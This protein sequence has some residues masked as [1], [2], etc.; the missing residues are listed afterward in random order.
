M[1]KAMIVVI[2]LGVVCF[3]VNSSGETGGLESS[4]PS[5]ISQAGI[6]DL[7]FKSVGLEFFL[8][9]NAKEWDKKEPFELKKNMML[10]ANYPVFEE[11]RLDKPADGC[12]LAEVIYQITTPPENREKLSCEGTINLLKGKGYKVTFSPGGAIERETVFSFFQDPRF[13]KEVMGAVNPVGS[14]PYSSAL[15]EAYSTPAS[16]AR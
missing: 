11:A 10:R 3:C 16:P 13:L 8:P 9:R 5:G 7:A 2:V 4:N 6:L 14:S 15:S 1:R 12:F